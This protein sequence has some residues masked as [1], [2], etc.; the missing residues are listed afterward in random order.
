MFV[1][2]KIFTPPFPSAKNRI[3]GLLILW[4]IYIAFTVANVDNIDNLLLVVSKIFTP[5]YPS[6][7]NKKFGLLVLW[8]ILRK[9]LVTTV[10]TIFIKSFF[11]GIVGYDSNYTIETFF[12]P[13]NKILGLLLL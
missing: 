4:I 2:S 6:G 9:L 13:I 12:P 3:F 7:K 8:I 1:E 11:I 5:L 10:D